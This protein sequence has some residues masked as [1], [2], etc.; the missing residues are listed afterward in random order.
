MEAPP[1]AIP[2]LRHSARPEID[3]VLVAWPQ[4]TDKHQ[5][6]FVQ[7][8]NATSGGVILS[9]KNI[10]AYRSWKTFRSKPLPMGEI[11]AA[12]GAGEGGKSRIKIQHWRNSLE[13]V[14][15]HAIQLPTAPPTLVPMAELFEQMRAIPELVGWW[16]VKQKYG[17]LHSHPWL[18][19]G[20]T[21]LHRRIMKSVRVVRLS[22]GD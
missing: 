9:V 18:E 12:M 8:I 20:M 17:D 4:W 6:G 11:V 16:T 3:D 22:R 21:E 19:A 15:A 14:E 13:Y 10:N 7:A 5:R 1:L 2:V